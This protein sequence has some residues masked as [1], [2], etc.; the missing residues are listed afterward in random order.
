MAGRLITLEGLDGAGKTTHLRWIAEWLEARGLAVR[1]TR[2]PGGTPLGE[3]LRAL[4]LEPGQHLH[5]ETE[6]LLMFA[7]RREH[8]DKVIV[9]ALAAGTWVVCDRFT[10][11]S[12]AYQG[13]GSDVPWEKIAQLERWV[14]PRLQPDLT[15]YFDVSPQLGRSRT[16]ASRPPDRYER[17]EA[18]F[19]ERVR[20]GYLRRAREEGGRLQVIDASRPV[21]E[22]HVELEEILSSI[23]NKDT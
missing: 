6:A 22:I 1:T 16:A 11:A 3:A 9:P 15:L 19:H 18:Q 23:C 12:Y 13:S 4:L 20:A 7:A 10:D 2:E 14:H 21:P 5:P 17:E 8:L